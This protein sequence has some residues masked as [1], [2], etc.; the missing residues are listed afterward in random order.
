MVKREGNYGL[1]MGLQMGPDFFG[2]FDLVHPIAALSIF[3]IL[4]V[5]FTSLL[6]MLTAV[7]FGNLM[8]PSFRI[9]IQIYF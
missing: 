6:K 1:V 7:N 3:K 8:L 4:G 5:I 9:F 2:I